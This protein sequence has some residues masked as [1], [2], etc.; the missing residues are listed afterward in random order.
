LLLAIKPSPKGLCL[1]TY[2]IY[3][4]KRIDVGGGEEVWGR[5]KKE[6]M[7]SIHSLCLD[8]HASEET[9]GISFQGLLENKSVS[10][11]SDF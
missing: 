10:Q 11:S 6:G 4:V 3:D 2:S 9:L 1:A 8:S 5:G 7:F